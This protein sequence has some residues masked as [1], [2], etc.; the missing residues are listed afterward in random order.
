MR[1]ILDRF[2][3]ITFANFLCSSVF[4]QQPPLSVKP[5]VEKK[6]RDLPS[7]ELY[8]RVETFPALAQAQAAATPHSLVAQSGGKVYLFSLGAPGGSSQGTRVAEVGPVPRIAA[9]EYLLRVNEASGAPG[10]V[11][12]VHSHPG[13]EAFLVLAG[14]QSI[15][16]PLGVTRVRAG[17][18]QTGHSADTPMQASSSGTSDLHA[19]ILFVV[20]ANRPFSSPASLP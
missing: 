8:W 14:E 2:A 16:T 6:V 3:A 12:S 11:T 9:A 10:S 1:H 15:R 19:L 20:D 4:A 17:S 7:G 18:A 5:L 13:S